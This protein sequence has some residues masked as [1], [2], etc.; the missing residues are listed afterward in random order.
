VAVV[1]DQGP[2][3]A[4]LEDT[5]ESPQE[6]NHGATCPTAGGETAM[7]P[8]ASGR[9]WAAEPA[10]AS[11]A[12]SHPGGPDGGRG[13]DS[14]GVWGERRVTFAGEA[15]YLG[16]D[17]LA[18]DPSPNPDPCP[19]SSAVGQ[20]EGHRDSVHWGGEDVAFPPHLLHHM[21][22][23]SNSEGMPDKREEIC[24]V[25]GE[26]GGDSDLGQDKQGMAAL[27]EEGA[28][29]ASRG[30]SMWEGQVILHTHHPWSSHDRPY[31]LPTPAL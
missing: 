14:G 31:Q 10:V 11:S 21:L 24:G 29:P 18:C 28:V 19:A 30:D 27:L 3:L 2:G 4:T 12:A 25:S 9:G 20:Q 23:G 17:V 15:G 13:R 16:C 1:K 22:P 7:I 6:D 8:G 26:D 5:G